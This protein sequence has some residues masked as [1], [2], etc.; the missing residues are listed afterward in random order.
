MKHPTATAHAMPVP[1]GGFAP[2]IR[3]RHQAGC[4]TVNRSV[5]AGQVQATSSAALAVAGQ[6]C[7]RWL[8]VVSEGNPA[9]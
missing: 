3:T 5:M 4:A 1:G 7:R 8:R 2:Y 6:A 9:G